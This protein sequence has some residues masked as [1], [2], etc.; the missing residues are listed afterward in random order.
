MFSESVSQSYCRELFILSF[1]VWVESEWSVDSRCSR[2]VKLQR[3]GPSTSYCSNAGWLW[4]R[5]LNS[6]NIYRYYSFAC[7]AV[8]EDVWKFWTW[9]NCDLQLVKWRVKTSSVHR[10]LK[11]FSGWLT[12]TPFGCQSRDDIYDSPS[13]CWAI[14]GSCQL[15]DFQ[16]NNFILLFIDCTE[17]KGDFVKWLMSDCI[18]NWCDYLYMCMSIDIYFW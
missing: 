17:L 11:H 16:F 18:C 12:S 14:S 5:H 15:S 7:Q 2:S 1:S 3:S 13:W 4:F 6:G 8:S 9:R 10:W